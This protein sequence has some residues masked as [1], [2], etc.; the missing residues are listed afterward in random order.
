MTFSQ[1]GGGFCVLIFQ[2]F[3]HSR[4]RER[5]LLCK[6]LEKAIVRHVIASLGKHKG[7]HNIG[8]CFI[9][10]ALTTGGFVSEAHGLLLKLISCTLSWLLTLVDLLTGWGS[11]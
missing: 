1:S 6:W 10:K 7:R 11:Q 8:S 2:T 5:P 9:D 3:Q 4:E